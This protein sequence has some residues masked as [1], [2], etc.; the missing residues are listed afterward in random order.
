MADECRIRLLRN[1]N[2]VPYSL[3]AGYPTFDMDFNGAKGREEYLINRDDMNAFYLVSMPPPIV[4]GD[5]VVVFTPRLMPGTGNLLTKKLSFRPH[6]Q[7]LPQ[8]PFGVDPPGY[9]NPYMVVTID[10]ETSKL[11]G[12]GGLDP[13]EPSTF[14]DISFDTSAVFL[15]VPASKHNYVTEENAEAQGAD[16]SDGSGNTGPVS[17]SGLPARITAEETSIDAEVPLTIV[18]PTTNYN[19]NWKQA[20]NPNFALFRS[21]IGRVNRLTDPLFDNAPPETI[22]FAGYSGSR[23]YL[24]D[25]TETTITPWNLTFKF[26]GKHVEDSNGQVFG[27]QHL[28]RSS[29]GGFYKAR[30]ANLSYIYNSTSTWSQMFRASGL[31]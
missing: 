12:G 1:A 2:G 20:L 9:N 26:I 19:L 8:D 7:D 16:G 24:W 11:S 4:F 6:A 22:L 25:G 3:R 17:Q 13:N 18:I 10:Y 5:T 27:W 30:R 31:I 15:K 23:S 29:R 21:L 28:Y 14:L